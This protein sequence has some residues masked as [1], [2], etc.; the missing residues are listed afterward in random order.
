MTTTTM[1]T[2]TKTTT[3]VAPTTTTAA[4]VTVATTQTPTTPPAP[5]TP[6]MTTTSPEP[7]TPP[8]TLPSTTP[9]PT[10]PPPPEV[11]T[12]K[13]EEAEA[14]ELV[15]VTQGD[16]EGG[17]TAP[18][19]VTVTMDLVPVTMADGLSGDLDPVMPL[20]IPPHDPDSSPLEVLTESPPSNPQEAEGALSVAEPPTPAS[21][22][23][24]LPMPFPVDQPA[25]SEPSLYL[26]LTETPTPVPTL[27]SQT[28][29]GS[30]DPDPEVLLWPKEETDVHAESAV[31][32][33]NDTAT[34]SAA[35]VLSGDGEVD[36][37]PQSYPH[38][39]DTDSELDYQYD[40]ADA[41]LPVSSAASLL[42]LSLHHLVLKA[43]AASHSSQPLTGFCT[44]CRN[45]AQT[46]FP[47]CPSFPTFPLLSDTSDLFV[48]LLLLQTDPK[49]NSCSSV[50]C[51]SR[52]SFK[53][54]SSFLIFFICSSVLF[55]KS[56]FECKFF[57]EDTV[58]VC[59]WH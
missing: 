43:S 59:L 55:V 27:D 15:V 20:I 46:G 28:E 13:E 56:H 42:L 14:G 35:T 52:F 6:P 21:S 53:C 1:T 34:F 23:F 22:G 49:K 26:D 50:R 45:K 18:N 4:P 33:E 48:V 24:P 38:L 2:T 51:S 31:Q 30:P 5:T 39:L 8:T 37:A 12:S 32:P 11:I 57:F 16:T 36:H 25:D 10:T 7:T 3:T 9:A 54:F 17:T 41:F 58:C 40:P 29:T 47:V 44:G 19:V